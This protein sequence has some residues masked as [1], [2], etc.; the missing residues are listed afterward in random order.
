[1]PTPTMRQS[2]RHF[3]FR[4]S[5]KKERSAPA[6][7]SVRCSVLFGHVH[8]PGLPDNV[9]LD[10][11]G[12]LHLVFDA[13]GD[14]PG[15]HNGVGIADLFGLDDDAHLP[16]CLNGIGSI[17]AVKGVG[18]LFQLFQTLDVVFQRLAACAGAGMASAACTRMASSVWGSTSL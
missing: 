16:T 13:L 11:T 10:L 4:R 15:Q 6:G 1:M 17:H 14:L 7:R 5:H 9:D 2:V 3:R 8:G 18:D 12:V